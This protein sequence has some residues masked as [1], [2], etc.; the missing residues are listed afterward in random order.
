MNSPKIGIF[1]HY[2]NQNLGDEAIIEATIQ[3]L[4]Q[5][6]PNVRLIGLSINPEDTHMR[7]GIESFPI[8]Y[9]AV[10]FNPQ[11]NQTSAQNSSSEQTSQ[12]NTQPSNLPQK[13]KPLP[14]RIARGIA[15]KLLNGLRKTITEIKFL[16][17]CKKQTNELD[18]LI[19]CGSNQFLD[20]FGGPWGFPYTILKWTLLAKSSNTKIAFVSVGA[21]PIYKKLSYRLLAPAIRRADY[22]SYRD[23]GSKKLIEQHI[24][25]VNGSIYP[26]I[27]HSLLTPPGEKNTH[28]NKL[29]AINPMPVFDPRYWYKTDSNKVDHY[30]DV[31][32]RF[33]ID[34]IKQGYYVVLFNNQKRDLDSIEDITQKIKS[35]DSSYL[36]NEHL[37]IAKH[38]VLDELLTT[39]SLA[40]IVVA[41][42]FHATVLPLR[43]GK[44]T[45][46]VSYYRKAKE[47]LDDIGLK[48]C[49]VDIENFSFEELNEKFTDLI[50]NA[51]NYA[52]T[53]NTK[54]K[55]YQK[56]LDEQWQ[57]IENLLPR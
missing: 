32:A 3:N 34:L 15:S 57:A 7:Y 54:F 46:G 42:R 21:G 37:R 33:T 44:P 35:I 13:K 16:R 39:L 31:M 14:I 19:I 26:D 55:D 9:N 51:D 52:Q 5:R 25:G 28:D 8:R 23:I 10:F 53:I 29:I 47:Q 45:F 18:L 6:I 2:G 36:E 41:T 56:Q 20:N 50:N 49:Y 1:G 12:T 40:D 30:I 17:E 22:L 43:L 27:A 11:K 24:A 4:R 48:G 38:D